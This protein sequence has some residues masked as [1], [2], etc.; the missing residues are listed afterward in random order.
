M[1]IHLFLIIVRAVLDIFIINTR[2]YVWS[3]Y[4][5]FYYKEHVLKFYKIKIEKHSNY[6][7]ELF[8]T[9]AILPVWLYIGY[10]Y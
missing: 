8:I 7:R 9:C 4:S 3:L 6:H 2:Y 1:V 5:P 10:W